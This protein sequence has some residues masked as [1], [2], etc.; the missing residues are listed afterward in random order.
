MAA[1]QAEDVRAAALALVDM[2]EAALAQALAQAVDVEARWAASVVREEAVRERLLLHT[3]AMLDAVADCSDPDVVVRLAPLALARAAAMEAVLPSAPVP[4]PPRLVFQT[5]D[6]AVPV[7]ALTAAL[8]VLNTPPEER[9]Q[10]QG[11]PAPS[12]SV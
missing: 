10:A 7:A 8:T 1:N 6:P 9:V 3:A 4:V 5:G 12:A 11:R 2:R